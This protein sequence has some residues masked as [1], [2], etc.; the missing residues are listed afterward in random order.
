MNI[1]GCSLRDELSVDF[2]RACAELAEARLRQDE[3][4]TSANRA[5]VAECWTRIDAVLK[6]IS[7]EG[8]TG[9]R[10]SPVLARKPSSRLGRYCIRLSRVFTSAVS[11]AMSCLVRLASDRFRCAPTGSTGFSSWAYGG[12]RNTVSHGRPAISSAMALLESGDPGMFLQIPP[13]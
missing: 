7:G 5:A 12:S 10:S 1:I 8:Y 6:V 11:S 13:E 9:L 2:S 4:D 3:K